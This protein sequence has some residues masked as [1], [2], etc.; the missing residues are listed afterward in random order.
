ME[1]FRVLTADGH[2]LAAR[3]FKSH[4]EAAKRAVVIA[5]ALGVPQSFYTRY[6]TWLAQQGCVAYTFDWRGMGER[7]ER[8]VGLDGATMAHHDA[9]RNRQAQPCALAHGFGG[10][11]GVEHL[12]LVFGRNSMPVVLHSKPDVC[13]GW[14]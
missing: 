4:G 6:A 1:S 11:E 3:C 5:C 8:N 13:A 14:Q 7:R 10:E 12:G 2:S 9:V